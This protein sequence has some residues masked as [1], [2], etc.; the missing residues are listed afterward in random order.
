MFIAGLGTLGQMLTVPML[1][2]TPRTTASGVYTEAQAKRGSEV[3][4][5]TCVPCHGDDLKGNDTAPALT[6]REFESFWNDQPLADLFDRINKTMPQDAPGSLMPQQSADL[7]AYLLSVM[8]GPVG[9]AELPAKL[10]ELK[11]IRIAAPKP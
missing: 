5:K 7:L 4:A 9:S 1:A 8:K 10:D 6:G 2:Q 11:D 3:F